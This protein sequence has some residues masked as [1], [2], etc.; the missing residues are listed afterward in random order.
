MECCWI[1]SHLTNQHVAFCRCD[2]HRRAE[3]E[4]E[5]CSRQEVL[6]GCDLITEKNWLNVTE[7]GKK[8]TTEVSKER[9]ESFLHFSLK[10]TKRVGFVI[11]CS[12]IAVWQNHGDKTKRL[13][14][15]V[16]FFFTPTFYHFIPSYLL[17]QSLSYQYFCFVAVEHFH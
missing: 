13:K 14:V 16:N 15:C 9:K 10:R 12:N 7:K 8:V 2:S 4:R 5:G 1:N 11:L 3:A 17:K 6:S